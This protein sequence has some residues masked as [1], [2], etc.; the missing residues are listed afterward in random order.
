M[1][2]YVAEALGTFAFVICG[3]GSIV[4]DRQTKGGVR[5]VG[6][7]V[8]FGVIV[9]AMKFA[10]GNISGARLNHAVTIAFILAKRFKLRQS[11]PLP[12]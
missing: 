10:L 11:L 3:E 2:R 5:Y 8:I 4:I 6:T 7:A 12:F 9:M 1:K